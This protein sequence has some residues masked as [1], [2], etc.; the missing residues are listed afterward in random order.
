MC[1]LRHGPEGFADGTPPSAMPQQQK[2]TRSCVTSAAVCQL[3]AG[4]QAGGTLS[5]PFLHF[6]NAPAGSAV[7]GG[8][9]TGELGA[10]VKDKVGRNL[11]SLH[12][13]STKHL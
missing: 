12:L 5:A 4:N 1:R 2:T 6:C 8:L 3:A 13:Q 7:R 9:R 10:G 11:I